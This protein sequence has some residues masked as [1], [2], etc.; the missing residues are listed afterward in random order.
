MKFT[1]KTAAPDA[2]AE[3]SPVLELVPADFSEA[4]VSIPTASIVIRDSRI[5]AA[6]ALVPPSDEITL[7]ANREHKQ[8]LVK[9]RTGLDKFRTELKAPILKLGKDIDEAYKAF[10]APSV[11]AEATLEASAIAYGAELQRLADIERK[12]QQDEIYRLRREAEAAEAARQ[13]EARK[14]QAEMDRQAREL[15]ESQ[16]RETAALRAKE[17]AQAA[18]GVEKSRAEAFAERIAARKREDDAAKELQRIENE[19][20]ESARRAQWERDEAAQKV[21]DAEDTAYRASLAAPRAKG[22][23]EIDTDV[24]PDWR[25]VPDDM[26]KRELRVAIVNAA[27]KAGKPTPGIT[28]KFVPKA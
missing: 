1:P 12:A 22:S 5:A 10:I 9:M 16:E 19:R 26:V 23:W 11:A 24:E 14:A 27:I 6:L 2:P 20:A 7:A 15:R 4:G 17:A 8:G 25:L 28:L 21:Q 18:A 3:L 13:A